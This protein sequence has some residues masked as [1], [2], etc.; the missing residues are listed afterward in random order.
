MNDV[1]LN[2]QRLPEYVVLIATLFRLLSAFLLITHVIPCQVREL[3]TDGYK[4]LKTILL[5]FTIFLLISNLAP[6]L[7][8]FCTNNQICCNIG[9]IDDLTFPL[10]GFG[11]FIAS[12]ILL[13]IYKGRYEKS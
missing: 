8:L 5:V 10:G 7:T 11:S 3:M 2:G 13:I 6:T 1:I 4:R 12:I 9:W